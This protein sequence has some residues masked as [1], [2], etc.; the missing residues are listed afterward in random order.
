LLA[1]VPGAFHEGKI[2]G[3][4]TGAG[5]RFDLLDRDVLCDPFLDAARHQLLDLFSAGAGP[6]T[7]GERLPGR[8]IRILALGHAHVAIDAPQD[9]ADEQDPGD[10]TR[11]GEEASG[12]AGIVM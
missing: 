3:R 10:V 7:K 2:N 9:G 5:V 6:W 4:Q 12:V 11:L 8:D 1:G